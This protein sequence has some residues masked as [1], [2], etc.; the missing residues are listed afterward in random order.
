MARVAHDLESMAQTD[1]VEIPNQSLFRA[2]EV[3]EIASV[4]PYVLRSWEAEF[5]DL[6][7]SRTQ[8]GPRVYRREDVERV[9]RI[10]QLL[11][12]EG[13]T[14]AGAR[15][16]LQEERPPSSDEPAMM[17]L[18]ELLGK[19]ARERIVQV[20]QGLRS[21]AAMLA[22]RPGAEAT[23]DHSFELKSSESPERSPVA[24]RS[25]TTAAKKMAKGRKKR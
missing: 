4:Q 8:G 19:D 25:K 14:L 2:A 7:V 23:H 16:K 9:L 17:S 15:R 1:R 10:K 12:A 18:A 6:G 11:F 20:K 24:L 5:P 21:L 3:C 22:R 13:L